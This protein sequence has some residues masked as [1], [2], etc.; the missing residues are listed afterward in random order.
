[1]KEISMN[2]IA[3][4]IVWK[5]MVEIRKKWLCEVENKNGL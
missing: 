4:G 2:S 3:V 5:Q 1:M